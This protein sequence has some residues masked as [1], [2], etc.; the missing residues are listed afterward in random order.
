MPMFLTLVRSYHSST[1]FAQR[2]VS[3]ESTKKLL[4][5]GSYIC[6]MLDSTGTV[7]KE[8]L[9]SVVCIEV[10]RGVKEEVVVL[11]TGAGSAKTLSDSELCDLSFSFQNRD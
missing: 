7:T 8:V 4:G 5:Q 1:D 10:K 9:L 2:I 11:S 6:D 3:V